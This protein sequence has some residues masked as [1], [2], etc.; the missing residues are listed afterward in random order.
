MLSAPG[1]WAWTAELGGRGVCAAPWAPTSG[2]RTPYPAVGRHLLLLQRV[3]PACPGTPQE[4]C[5]TKNSSAPVKGWRPLQAGRKEKHRDGWGRRVER[6][7][8]RDPGEGAVPRQQVARWEAGD[9]KLAHHATLR[10]QDP[11]YRYAL[12]LREVQ[13]HLQRRGTSGRGGHWAD[14]ALGTRL[15]DSCAPARLSLSKRRL[16][17]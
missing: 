9:T 16:S 10:V 6:H 17:W 11:A 14:G 5:K 15:G 12:V 3:L 13:C 4:T 7:S 2:C 1:T 8:R